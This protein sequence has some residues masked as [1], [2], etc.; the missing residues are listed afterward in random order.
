[1][2][3]DKLPLYF[4]DVSITNVLEHIIQGKL[5]PRDK[6]LLT[7]GELR[8]LDPFPYEEEG[9][10]SSIG[11]QDLVPYLSEEV[12]VGIKFGRRCLKCHIRHRHPDE[13]NDGTFCTLT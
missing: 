2:V 13:S 6:R 8:L 9:G 3:N 7:M 10:V 11:A 5:T 1:M 4:A 12:E